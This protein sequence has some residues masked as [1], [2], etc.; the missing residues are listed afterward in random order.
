MNNEMNDFSVPNVSNAFG[1]SPSPANFIRP[2]KR[3]LSSMSPT[4]VEYL[5]NSTFHLATGAAGGSRIIT[6]TIQSLWRTLDLKEN[7]EQAI[8]SP[9]FH[10]QLSPDEVMR[11]LS[12]SKSSC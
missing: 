9:R 8:A 6:S 10:D 5:E 3:P 4:I 1:Y 12:Q 11:R 2:G 7:L